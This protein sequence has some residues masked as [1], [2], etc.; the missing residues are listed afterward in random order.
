M[1]L[2]LLLL[3]NLSLHHK[4]FALKFLPSDV[5]PNRTSFLLLFVLC[6]ERIPR[7]N[8]SYLS[9]PI[10]WVYS[11]VHRFEFEKMWYYR[12]IILLE[13]VQ[14]LSL[15]FP[16]WCYMFFIIWTSCDTNEDFFVQKNIKIIRTI[17]L[18]T[19]DWA[20]KML[21]STS[22]LHLEILNKKSNAKFKKYETKYQIKCMQR[23]NKS[24]IKFNFI[25]MLW[26][27]LRKMSLTIP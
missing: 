15:M 3:F 21:N 20:H 12:Y 10:K 16:Y 11:S 9:H 22:N 4:M 19:T 26:R 13:R 24:K 14:W 6:M 27:I 25:R 8:N 2:S 7:I 23:R 1:L 18:I 5:H 17:H